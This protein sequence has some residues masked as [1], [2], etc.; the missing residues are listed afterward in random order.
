MK[1]RFT[2]KQDPV[3]WNTLPDGKVDVMICLNHVVF[4]IDQCSYHFCGIYA[5]STH[6]QKMSASVFKTVGNQFIHV[7]D[8][9]NCGNCKVTKMRAHQKRLRF[10]I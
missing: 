10:I 3:T 6:F 8:L 5:S 2:E 7:I 1:A 9:S 4:L